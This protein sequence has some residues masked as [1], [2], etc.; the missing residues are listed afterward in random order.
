MSL[1]EN[2]L[3]RNNAVNMKKYRIGKVYISATM[4]RVPTD[5]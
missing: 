2:S 3:V 5:R 1:T 4:A